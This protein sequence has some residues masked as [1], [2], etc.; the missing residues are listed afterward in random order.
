LVI[1][2]EVPYPPTSGGRQ[3]SYFLIKSLA[4]EY[5][6]DVITFAEHPSPESLAALRSLCA[7]VY[8]VPLPRHS[9][10]LM[11]FVW[12]NLRRAIRGINPLIDRFSAPAVR[13]S[14]RALLDEQQYDLILIEHSW[15]AHYISDI[16]ASGNRK[17]LT[18]LDA[19]NVESDLWRQ[20]YERP[21]RWWYKPA[22]YRYW[23]SAREYEQTYLNQ[24]D[25]VVGMSTPDAEKLAQLAPSATVAVI[26]N[27]VDVV[28]DS[29]PKN[30]AERSPVVGFVG[31]LDYPPN[32]Q[33]LWWFLEH[34]WP[35]VRSRVPASELLVIGPTS[36]GRLRRKCQPDPSIRLA[37]YVE[38]LEPHLN[39]VAVMVVPLLHG[40]GTRIKILDAWAHGI[41]VVSTSK[42][43]EGLEYEHRKN[44]W[45][46]DTPMDFAAGIVY[47]LAD[48]QTRQRL[49][50]AGHQLVSAQYSWTTI[51][52]QLR[53]V[54]HQSS[55][56]Q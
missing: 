53:A 33:G 41:P 49:A 24:F 36:S 19:Q 26:P 17:T 13:Q 40:S 48:G 47:L 2:P 52:E 34:I 35:Q 21:A 25:L 28:Y 50:E 4:A 56:H 45:I 12:R 3:R 5:A 9:K 6:L 27:G 55:S 15:V 29:V 18:I 7:N 30:Q 37:G 43:A 39:R 44:L 20:Y 8:V 1:S 14:V 22:A 51:G 46:G 10:A 42:G 38:T 32:E 11:A 16:K 23:Q 31:S 54:I